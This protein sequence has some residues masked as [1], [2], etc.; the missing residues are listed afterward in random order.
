MPRAWVGRKR[1]GLLSCVWSAGRVPARPRTGCLDSVTTVKSA[2]GA[3]AEGR[4]RVLRPMNPES[5]RNA[6]RAVRAGPV[7]IGGGA[8]ISVQSM[9]ATH[10]QEVDKTV[11]QVERLAKS[12]AALVRV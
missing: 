4:A 7:Q 2:V 1:T 3:T 6:T 5:S 11:E 10:T 12:G 9:C 8:P